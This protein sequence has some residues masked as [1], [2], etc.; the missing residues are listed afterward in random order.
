MSRV[1]VM[2]GALALVSAFSG[3][4]TRHDLNGQPVRMPKFK[5]VGALDVAPAAPAAS[6]PAK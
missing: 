4:A 6:T 1:I 5:A 2:L 3:C